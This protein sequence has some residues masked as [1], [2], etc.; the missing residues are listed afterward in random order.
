MVHRGIVD[1]VKEDKLID[2][3]CSKRIKEACKTLNNISKLGLNKGKSSPE[4]NTNKTKLSCMYVNARSLV[5]KREELELAVEQRD[6]DI[7][8][9]SESW[10]TDSISD[11]EVELAGYKII[12]KDRVSNVKTRGG[13]V[14]WYF[15]DGINVVLRDEI[16][17]DKFPEAIFCSIESNGDKTLLGL[18]YRPPDS[19]VDNDE[20]LYSLFEQACD[21]DNN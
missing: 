8:G 3:V 21:G 2:K 17:S 10:L 12:R 1:A 15:K 16:C 19:L 4:N 20:G 18:C 13:G 7:I 6:Y 14:V 9:F 11:A 5:N